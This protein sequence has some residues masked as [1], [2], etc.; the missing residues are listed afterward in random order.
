[1]SYFWLLCGAWWPLQWP[2]LCIGSQPWIEPSSNRQCLYTPL[3]DNIR[4][5]VTF[6]WFVGGICIF[7]L[8]I[9]T[10]RQNTLINYVWIIADRVGAHDREI[11]SACSHSQ[12]SLW[13]WCRSQA[14]GP[15]RWPAAKE[16][17][18]DGLGR[19]RGPLHSANDPRRPRPSNRFQCELNVVV[20]MILIGQ[21]LQSVWTPFGS[22]LS[23]TTCPWCLSWQ[24]R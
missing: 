5:Y 3:K 12:S 19:R 18:K 15:A 16:A 22:L 4:S 21:P 13:S 2:P 9:R 23:S 11:W 7:S 1:M 24:P 20:N 10:C 8:S 14:L 6:C 17:A